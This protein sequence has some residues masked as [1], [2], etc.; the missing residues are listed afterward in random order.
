MQPS[1]MYTKGQLYSMQRM[2]EE[3]WRCDISYQK[4]SQGFAPTGELQLKGVQKTHKFTRKMNIMRAKDQAYNLQKVHIRDSIK[5]EERK[6]PMKGERGVTQEVRDDS[7]MTQELQ[8]WS[9]KK[10]WV[11][12]CWEKI[13]SE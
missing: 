10:M 13:K 9:F 7:E 11:V 2:P 6:K 4:G 3:S 5:K 1:P 8:K 12:K